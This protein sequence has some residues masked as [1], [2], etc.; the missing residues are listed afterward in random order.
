MDFKEKIA[1]FTLEIFTCKDLADIAITGLEEGFDSEA[2]RILAGGY[3]ENGIQLRQYLDVCMSEL[4]M[5][6][7]ENK[8]AVVVLARYYVREMIKGKSDPLGA[9]TLIERLLWQN[10]LYYKD[11]GLWDCYL[12]HLDIWD[13]DPSGLSNQVH[14]G[15]LTEKLKGQLIQ[16]LNDFAL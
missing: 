8:E 3:F 16:W 6:L 11:I 5:K 10:S 13:F 12:I 9:F 14:N 2:L 1:A 15:E 7:P 4:D